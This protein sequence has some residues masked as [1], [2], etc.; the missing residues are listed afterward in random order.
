LTF[1]VRDHGPGIAQAD[2]PHLFERFYR[3][4][5]A[6]SRTSGTGMGLWIVRG[7]LAAANGHVW[8]ENCEDGG[9]RF[10]LHVP[11]QT[12]HMAPATSTR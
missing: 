4:A 1:Q 11:A 12:Q 3:G 9:A 6:K 5:A 10:T 7:L 2:L 8:A